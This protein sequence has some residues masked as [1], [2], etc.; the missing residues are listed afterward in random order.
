MDAYNAN[1]TSISAAIKNFHLQKKENKIC[2]LGDM[3]EL[4]EDSQMEHAAIV[5]ECLHLDLGTVIF[6]GEEF[7]KAKNEKFIFVKTCE[8]ALELTALKDLKHS[9]ILL[10]ASRGMQFEKLLTAF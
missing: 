10:K 1:P 5:S 2:I 3:F 9:Y 6:I 8:E 4:G 7:L